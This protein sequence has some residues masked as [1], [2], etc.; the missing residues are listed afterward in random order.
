LQRKIDLKYVNVPLLLSLNTDKSK[1]V[2]LNV[3]VGPQFGINVGSSITT[4][5]QYSS[6]NKQPVLSVRKNDVGIAYGAGLDFGLNA[7]RTIRLGVGYRA[8]MGLLDVSNNNQTLTTDS[9]YVLDRSHIKSHSA[10]AGLSI[11]F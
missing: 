6:N 3:V 10:H 1:L 5:G 11:M 8:V 7:A 2:N 9:Y 4:S